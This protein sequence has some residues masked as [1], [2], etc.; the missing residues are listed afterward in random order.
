MMS[1]DVEGGEALVGA[2]GLGGGQVA[3]T[4]EHGEPFEHA[5]LVVEQQ[6]V[7]PVDDGPQRLLPRQGG[8]RPAGEQTEPIVESGGE[9]FEREGSGPGG[10]E[11]D[12]QWQT[13]EPKADVA[14]HVEVVLAELDGSSRRPGPER[15]RARPHRRR[16][17]AAPAR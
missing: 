9:L 4:G 7:A 14:D 13:I 12:R 2:D 1:C 10:R 5:L 16:R 15:R 11:L 17:A 3:T 8:A 6:L